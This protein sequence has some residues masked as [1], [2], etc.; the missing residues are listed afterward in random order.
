[1]VFQLTVSGEH[2][3]GIGKIKYMGKEHGEAWDL[4]SSIKSALDPN[5]IKVFRGIYNLDF[6]TGSDQILKTSF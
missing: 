6:Y 1:M 4:M 2:G 5:S 3:V